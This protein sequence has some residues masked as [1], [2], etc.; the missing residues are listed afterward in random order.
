MRREEVRSP[1]FQI[2]LS[3]DSVSGTQP[4]VRGIISPLQSQCILTI[5]VGF[6]LKSNYV[7]IIVF[8][9]MLKHSNSR[10]VIIIYMPVTCYS[11][12][13]VFVSNF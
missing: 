7:S 1:A 10:Y 5:T 8:G 9:K 3:G 6:S 11:Y 4:Q 13:H 2:T 12:F